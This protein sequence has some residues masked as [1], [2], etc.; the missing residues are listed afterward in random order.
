M[1]DRRLNLGTK[2]TVKCTVQSPTARTFASRSIRYATFGLLSCRYP[3]NC[4][5]TTLDVSSAT[6]CIDG[7]TGALCGTCKQGW[8]LY[9]D[10]H[11]EA[12][13]SSSGVVKALELIGLTIFFSFFV[14]FEAFVA[15]LGAGTK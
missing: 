4:N 1:T 6:E 3:S 9:K 5:Q 13:S 8:I 12:C 14:G 10:G 2:P 7:S 11:C 15:Y